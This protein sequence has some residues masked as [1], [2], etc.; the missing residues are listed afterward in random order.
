MSVEQPIICHIWV[1]ISTCFTDFIWILPGHWHFYKLCN[2]RKITYVQALQSHFLNLKAR[3]K[4][5]GKHLVLWKFKCLS[6]TFRRF[7]IL[8]CRRHGA[9]V[10]VFIKQA[11]S[12]LHPCSAW[13]LSGGHYWNLSSAVVILEFTA[14]KNSWAVHGAGTQWCAVCYEPEG[15]CGVPGL[16]WAAA[17][18]GLV[19][20]MLTAAPP[21][22]L[23]SFD[24]KLT[25]SAETYY[26]YCCWFRPFLFSL[27]CKTSSPGGKFLR[28]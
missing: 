7:L 8:L 24:S 4:L 3:A 10:Q 13:Q 15:C 5:W 26:L 19:H 25:T 17:V 14:F 18:L 12:T 22:Q 6:C 16:A 23:G 21:T 20:T 11:F 2:K 9:V 27:Q 28:L 1:E